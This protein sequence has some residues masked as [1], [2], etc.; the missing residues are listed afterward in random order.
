MNPSVPQSL[1]E[2]TVSSREIFKGQI[3][4]V[5]LDEAE[6]PSGAVRPR[7][8]VE[9]P[10]GAAVLGLLPN[11]NILL[12]KQYRYPLQDMLYEFPA[13]KLDPGETPLTSIKRELEEETG[14]LA[15]HWE[16]ITTIVTSPGF[17]DEKITLFKATGL[18]LSPNPRREEDEFIEVLE[19]SPAQLKQMIR[20]CQLIDAKTICALAVM[21]PEALQ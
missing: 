10:G 5:R 18:K 19:A 7:E 1:A 11:G 6:T 14:Y 16:E 17:C 13:G 21:M 8:V 2:K 15:D 20:D 3:L 9:H 12:V 4:R